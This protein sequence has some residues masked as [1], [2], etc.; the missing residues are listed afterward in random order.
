MSI[1]SEVETNSAELLI[2]TRQSLEKLNQSMF[3]GVTDESKAFVDE[4]HSL[5]SRLQRVVH[6][7]HAES[8]ATEAARVAAGAEQAAAPATTAAAQPASTTTA[9]TT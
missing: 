6:F 3:K 4:A 7:E 8:T 2:R 9:A 1:I 5:C